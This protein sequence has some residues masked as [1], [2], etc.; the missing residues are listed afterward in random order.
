M[1]I[2]FSQMV[3]WR[4]IGIDGEE[5]EGETKRKRKV[6]KE[7]MQKKHLK[8]Y[9]QNRKDPSDCYSSNNPFRRDKRIREVR[10]NQA[11]KRFSK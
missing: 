3:K 10:E 11:L 1:N 7:N 5:G 9:V 4:R 6:T 8:V 2:A